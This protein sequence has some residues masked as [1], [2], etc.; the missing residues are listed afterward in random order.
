MI[1]PDE[2]RKHDATGLAELVRRRD[3]SASELLEA[4]IARTE[5]VQPRLNAVTTCMYEVA[6]ARAASAPAGPLG[7]VPFLLKDLDQ[8]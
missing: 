7:G 8:H 5:Q 1:S 2:Y 6:R 4:A 3:V